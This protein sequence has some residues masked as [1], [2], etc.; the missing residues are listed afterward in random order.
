MLFWVSNAGAQTTLSIAKLYVTDDAIKNDTRSASAC[1]FSIQY[2]T[3][4]AAK[5][6]KANKDLQN[7]LRFQYRDT[8]FVFVVAKLP[9]R[10]MLDKPDGDAPAALEETTPVPSESTPASAQ[11]L[12]LIDGIPAGEFSESEPQS[13]FIFPAGEL[14]SQEVRL[15][16]ENSSNWICATRITSNP[17]TLYRVG[18]DTTSF[19]A[20][21][22]VAAGLKSGGA[23]NTVTGSLG[24]LHD[25]F[26]TPSEQR[27]CETKIL[28]FCA[29][30]AAGER[31]KAVIAVA[32]SAD[33]V[34]KSSSKEVYAQ[35]IA[36]P[37]LVNGQAGSAVV[38]YYRYRSRGGGTGTQG[39]RILFSATRT[40]WAPDSVFG[41]AG[42]TKSGSVL[43]RDSVISHR[44][45][46]LSI[47]ALDIRQRFA[48][49]DHG[50]DA[51]GNSFGFG[52][53]AGV[54]VRQLAGEAAGDKKYLFNAL[55]T[56]HRFFYGGVLAVDIRL[57]AVTASLEM[58][59]LTHIS[60]LFQPTFAFRFDAPFFTL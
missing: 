38:D 28:Y 43:T 20:D 59:Y 37:M 53:E 27:S 44:G 14:E 57:R 1:E 41:L 22:S 31:L 25:S 21:G 50:S 26:K 60:G 11:V 13:V 48:F 49:I 29:S 12:V 2:V 39:I 32:S 18:Q 52:V 35:A 9:P 5:G 3:V 4:A 40:S 45:K 51:K 17:V 6:K 56:D 47:V 54:A 34:L 24:I 46:S 10:S 42:E 15:A 7:R 16:R 58:P 30:P 23:S 55:R 19:I 33:T 8:L 36:S